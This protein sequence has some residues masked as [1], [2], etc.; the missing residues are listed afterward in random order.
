MGLA[1]G[2]EDNGRNEAGRSLS[3]AGANEPALAPGMMADFLLVDNSVEGHPAIRLAVEG[4][5][6]VQEF[7]PAQGESP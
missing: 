1:G 7:L 4:G 3:P 6:I 2:R 5:L